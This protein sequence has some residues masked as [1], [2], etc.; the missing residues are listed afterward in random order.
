MHRGY[1]IDGKYL[2]EDLLGTGASG[3]VYRAVQIGLDRQVAVKLL[4]RDAGSSR[5]AIEKLR[6]EALAVSHLRHPNIVKVVDFGA[7]EA[8]GAYIV[9]ELLEG[10]SL[11]LELDEEG[12]RPPDET[13]ALLGPACRA[14]GAAH[15][16]GLVHRDLKP[17]NLFVARR[18]NGQVLIVLDFGLAQFQGATDDEIGS[19][20]DVVV[21]TPL[22]M[23]PEQ[24]D[25]QPADV[26]S[27]VYSL[28]C[29]LFEMLTGRPPFVAESIAEVLK[30]HR[31]HAPIRPSFLSPDVPL[32]LDDIVL[33]CLAKNPD[34]RYPSAISLAE[35]LGTENV[36]N[37][38]ESAA[39]SEPPGRF[40]P[41]LS[42]LPPESSLF[43]G[44][45][46]E[47]QYIASMLDECR[48]L[49]LVGPGGIG[50]TRLAREVA[51]RVAGR[52]PDGV[53]LVELA[54]LHDRE[55]VT[56]A[57]A[58]VLGL[59]ETAG[60]PLLD[61]L[62]EA[63]AGRTM[64]IVLDNCEHLVAGCA[65]IATS[66][67]RASPGLRLL[68]TSREVIGAEGETVWTVPPLDPPAPGLSASEA[69]ENDAVRL[70]VDRA[71]TSRRSFELTDG[72]TAAVSA[73]CRALD[74]LPL[75]IELA[76]ARVA[77]IS[78]DDLAARMS[79]RL[80]IL[81]GGGRDA[82]PHHRTL[83]AALDWSHDLLSMDEQ[84]ILRRLSVFAG[85][86]SFEAAE[87]IC[88]GA[89][90]D[91]LAVFDVLRR[92][93]D[94]SL[95]ATDEQSG[96]IRLRLLE[97][98]QAYARE[99]LFVSGEEAQFLY[100]HSRW[101]I[102]LAVQAHSEVDGP[103]RDTWNRRL[104]SEHDNL[105]AGL[106]RSIDSDDVESSLR[107]ATA[108]SRFWATAG[109]LG[110]GRQ[111]IESA[112]GITG[113]EPTAE[114]AAALHGV[115]RI[116]LIQ[117]DHH[118]A[119]AAADEAISIR[120]EI[121]DHAGEASTLAIKAL[122]VGRL[123]D[124]DAA[125]ALHTEGLGICRKF[126]L[127]REA[128]ESVFYLGLLAMYR[129]DFLAAKANFEESLAAYRDADNRHKVVVLLHNIGEVAWFLGD[130]EGACAALEECLSLAEG[131]GLRRLVAD[132][133]RSLGRVAAD[134]GDLERANASFAESWRLQ[135]EIG[136]LEGVIEVVEGRACLAANAGLWRQAVAL[137]AS[138]ARAREELAM[139]S[140][141][142]FKGEF[143]RRIAICHG[144]MSTEEAAL[145]R[146]EGSAMTLD[147][148]ASF[149]LS[150]DGGG[151]HARRS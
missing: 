42:N 85:G 30:R 144:R 107:L 29:I 115:A 15:E 131:L 31:T 47:L 62:V 150:L 1:C 99:Q 46:S 93:V 130:L 95:V 35:A 122:A 74:G 66:L 58:Q 5:M 120:R 60:R 17:S 82:L 43:V 18:E 4:R 13:I 22:Y 25:G 106:R 76:A 75:A 11:A 139:P 104:E 36:P 9:F 84:A 63:C 112:L 52:F 7:S 48:Q 12:R 38:N 149:A 123:G 105:R 125:Y 51:R 68:A 39:G 127:S 53:W 40:S 44:R 27:D 132:T 80:R 97:T 142:G 88:A 45:K 65:A 101:C 64:L 117:A 151:G 98:V 114:R 71:R 147:E 136:N 78:V 86:F 79:N 102:D 50:K 90:V 24:C 70:F 49:T 121:A 129:G 103:D 118:R 113:D 146:V 148:A 77:S 56:Y 69:L 61:G 133:L 81:D 135:R 3:S 140:D 67:L 134:L 116:A 73:V 128:T 87:R 126:G 34:D 28:G 33:R 10:R 111:W 110:E 89:P 2:L 108:M 6:R 137:A 96:E 83:R 41:R 32:W 19:L 143:E 8:A 26:R 72:S 119:V 141:S 138:A 54:G 91:E 124:Y 20:S 94:K 59:R 109:F 92:L 14:V 37:V 57:V 16:A 145:A 21:G 100:R 55:H 23:A